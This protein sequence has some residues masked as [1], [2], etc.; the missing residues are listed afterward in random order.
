MLFILDE[1]RQLRIELYFQK[2]YTFK[3]ALLPVSWPACFGRHL[4]QYR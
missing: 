1:A 2:V 4:D 3:M